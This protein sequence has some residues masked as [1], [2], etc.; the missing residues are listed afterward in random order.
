MASEREISP[1][2]V[3]LGERLRQAILRDNYV[4]DLYTGIVE[5]PPEYRGFHS[6]E[7]PKRRRRRKAASA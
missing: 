5:W 7:L 4:I 6:S 2:R 1:S 3:S